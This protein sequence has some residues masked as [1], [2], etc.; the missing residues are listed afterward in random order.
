MRTIPE[1]VAEMKALIA[2][3]EQHTGLP[4]KK[5]YG[6]DT[7]KFNFDN[8]GAGQPT[9]SYYENSGPTISISAVG[10]DTITLNP[11]KN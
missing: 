3:L 10:E 2:E 8:M 6:E 5:D 11:I 4:P 9:F 7:I 1:I